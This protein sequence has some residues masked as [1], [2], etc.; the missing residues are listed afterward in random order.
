MFPKSW[1]LCG[2]YRV[3]G[4]TKAKYMTLINLYMQLSMTQVVFLMSDIKAETYPFRLLAVITW[5]LSLSE[6]GGKF[7]SVV[8][9]QTSIKSCRVPYVK[10]LVLKQS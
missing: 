1:E 3:E 4:V 9:I 8:H 10:F 5:I 7:L 6:L 2:F